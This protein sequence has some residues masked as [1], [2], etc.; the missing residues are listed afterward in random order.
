M[1]F[2]RLQNQVKA[3][4]KCNTFYE[5][6]K[7]KTPFGIEHSITSKVHGLKLYATNCFGVV[8]WYPLIVLFNIF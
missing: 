5:T 8:V 7:Q 1:D 2:L 3:H 6:E 4:L